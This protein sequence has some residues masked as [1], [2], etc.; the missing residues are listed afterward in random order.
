MRKQQQRET[1]LAFPGIKVLFSSQ[2]PTPSHHGPHHGDTT[3]NK[4][5]NFS[6]KLYNTNVSE[7]PKT[8]LL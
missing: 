8:A 7:D 2:V 1:F 6:T 5:L 4:T 3:N